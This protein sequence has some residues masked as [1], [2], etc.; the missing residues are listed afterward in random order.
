MVDGVGG[1]ER[2]LKLSSGV[3]KVPFQQYLETGDQ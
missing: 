3:N 2:C 1:S